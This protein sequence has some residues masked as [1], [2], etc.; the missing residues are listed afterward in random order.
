MLTEKKNGRGIPR[1]VDFS[2]HTISV[3]PCHAM[4]CVF[5]CS[6]QSP[7]PLS[8]FFFFSSSLIGRLVFFYLIPLS[9]WRKGKMDKRA[10]RAKAFLHGLLLDPGWRPRD[11]KSMGLALHHVLFSLVS[12][13]SYFSFL[14]RATLACNTA[15]LFSSLFLLRTLPF[16]LGSAIC[17]HD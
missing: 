14:S 7:L 12:C 8:F 13:L 3:H 11:Q 1:F 10:K 16:F 9:V 17:W 2:Q 5:A 15:M 4:F 6:L